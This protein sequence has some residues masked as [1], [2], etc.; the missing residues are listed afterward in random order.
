MGGCRFAKAHSLSVGPMDAAGVPMVCRPRNRNKAPAPALLVLLLTAGLTLTDPD[1][2]PGAGHITKWTA[3][4]PPKKS[5]YLDPLVNHLLTLVLFTYSHCS[6]H[7]RGSSSASGSAAPTRRRTI[8]SLQTF[9]EHRQLPEEIL[10]EYFQKKRATVDLSS[11]NGIHSVL[12]GG[13]GKATKPQ[14]QSTYCGCGSCSNVVLVLVC[15]LDCC[16]K[17]L[18]LALVSTSGEIWFREKEQMR[19]NPNPPTLPRQPFCSTRSASACWRFF[20]SG[21]R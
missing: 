10:T 15:K 12:G 6:V 2:S 3:G 19:M 9:A 1:P 14:Q 18:A 4:S 20:C 16:S 17:K 5:L 13:G 7:R 11:M 21:R 8:Y